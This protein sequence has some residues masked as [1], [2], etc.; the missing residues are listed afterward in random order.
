MTMA[1][2]PSTHNTV[3][4]MSGKYGMSGSNTPSITKMIPNISRLCLNIVNDDSWMYLKETMEVPAQFNGLVLT[5][6][7]LLWR[8]N[9]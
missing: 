2:T 1:I 4:I 5:N 3:P 9:R 8:I 6:S 7:L